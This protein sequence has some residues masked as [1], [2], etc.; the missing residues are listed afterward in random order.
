MTCECI[1]T[2]F[3]LF[4]G[5]RWR[6]IVA[7]AHPK[8]YRPS[9]MSSDSFTLTSHGT[10][11]ATL[12][13]LRLGRQVR[14]RLA[15][16]KLL[17]LSFFFGQPPRAIASLPMEG[18]A[19]ANACEERG[20]YSSRFPCIML[21]RPRVPTQGKGGGGTSCNQ[22]PLAIALELAFAR[23]SMLAFA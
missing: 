11:A 12:S 23:I 9:K 2:P 14:G 1:N 20:L 13:T 22:P 8:L 18:F 6:R 5:T 21:C 7:A 4:G 10:E 17:D 15:E 16:V 3:G 19:T